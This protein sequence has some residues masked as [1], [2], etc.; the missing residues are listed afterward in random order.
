MSE[1]KVTIDTA[2]SI[3]PE[4]FRFT[5]GYRHVEEGEWYYC[6]GFPI[7][8]DRYIDCDFPVLEKIERWRAEDGEFYWG[9]DWNFEPE[10]ARDYFSVTDDTLYNRGEY[11][12]TEDDAKECGEMIKETIR[13]FWKKKG[14]E[15]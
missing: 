11:F 5:G 2:T 6:D 9:I 3:A 8:S 4:G 12:Q 15:I 7:L 13:Q 10:K 14:F 1:K